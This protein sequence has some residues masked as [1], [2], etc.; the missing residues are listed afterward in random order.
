MLFIHGNNC[1]AN[2]PQCS[3]IR[4]LS[5][6]FIHSF[7]HSFKVF[8]SQIFSKYAAQ[9]TIL[10]HLGQKCSLSVISRGE[11]SV[12]FCLY[13]VYAMNIYR[14]GGTA[15]GILDRGIRYRCSALL[16]DSLTR[17]ARAPGTH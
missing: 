15:P 17:V 12:E 7:I 10:S 13:T 14:E 2:V 5:A 6:L 4:I 3:V 8:L 9:Y 1:C 16:A 11:G